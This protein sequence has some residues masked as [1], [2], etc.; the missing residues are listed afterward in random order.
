MTNKDI[1]WVIHYAQE[2]D[3][4]YCG[5]HNENSIG[6]SGFA[7]IHTHGLDVYNHKEI[8][9]PIDIGNV[10]GIIINDCGL[11]IK[12]NKEKFEPGLKFGVIKDYPVLFYEFEKESDTLYMFLPD[13][14][15]RFPINE[16][17]EFPFNQQKFYASI[18]E[19]ENKEIK[20]EILRRKNYEQ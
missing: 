3:C 19:E 13:K 8:C 10:A 1:D 11:K 9:I 5:K 6:L 7:N 15:G 2:H 16:D 4:D 20:K 17:C 14:Y 18:I 12:F